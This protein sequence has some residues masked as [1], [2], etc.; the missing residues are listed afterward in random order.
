MTTSNGK[1]MQNLGDENCD[2][3]EQFAWL[4][5]PIIY[6]REPHTICRR[7]LVRRLGMIKE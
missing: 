2:E 1:K 7:C 3:C 6:Q 4:L 5:I